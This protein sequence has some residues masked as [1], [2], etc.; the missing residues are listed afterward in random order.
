MH[1]PAAAS[2]PSPLTPCR[3]AVDADADEDA[4]EDDWSPIR[5]SESPPHL[6]WKERVADAKGLNAEDSVSNLFPHD[7]RCS[8]ILFGNLAVV[9]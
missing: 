6:K 1:P 4:D 5:G 7:K 3:T 8:C 2:S 9:L